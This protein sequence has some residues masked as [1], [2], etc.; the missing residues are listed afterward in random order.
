[1]ATALLLEG[2]LVKDGNGMGGWKNRFCSLTFANNQFTLDYFVGDNKAEK[3]GAFVFA[4]K[5][6]FA[7]TADNGENKFCF[8]L[9]VIDSDS[10]SRKAG[11]KVTFSAPSIE[12]FTLWEKA[13]LNA[14]APVGVMPG[15]GKS[16]GKHELV[17]IGSSGY[18]GVSTLRVLAGFTK[19]FIIKAGVRDTKKVNFGAGVQVVAADMAQ[20]KTL[21]PLVS[22]ARCAFVCVPGTA[23]RTQL[24]V[25]AIKACKDNGVQHVVVLSVTS[26][27][28]KP[29]TIFADQ[30]RPIEEYVKTVGM[31]Y[32]IVRLPLFMENVLGQL[33][34]VASTLQFSTALDSEIK[35]NATSVGDIGEAIAK[36]MAKPELHVNKTLVLA[37]NT[38]TQN[39]FADAFSAV[40]EKKVA[41]VSISYEDSKLAMVGAGFPEWQADGINELYQM[42]ASGEPALVEAVS[43]LHAILKRD[44]ATPAGL[45]A[46]VAPGLRAMRD[47]A[48]YE[49]KVAEEEAAAKLANM[50]LNAGANADAIKAAEK[51]AADKAA[52]EK[53][54]AHLKKTRAMIHDGGMVLKKMGNETGFKLRFVWVDEET[55]KLCWSKAENKTSPFKSI[56]LNGNVVLTKP[57]FSS[58][59]PAA[60]FGA[61]EPDGHIVTV[62]P[63]GQPSVDLKIDGTIHDANAW[64]TAIQLLCVSKKR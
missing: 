16:F 64:H 42:I 1:M 3:K 28:T 36:I 55:K 50:K 23:D 21:A 7:K 10:V 61:A 15:V 29:G 57:E 43:D 5:S 32:T 63:P 62:T 30:F 49:T 47:A 37:G 17:V 58:A 19:D 41:H 51:A 44:L 14:K 18:V 8:T 12:A 40:L 13:F 9:D 39:D 2:W 4:R 20:P 6:G 53:A 60:M 34:S 31:P 45:A 52:A 22:G 46:S 48:E 35:Y 11:G 26:V 54:A 27:A 24:A 33:Q 59:K 38:V 56:D 25:N